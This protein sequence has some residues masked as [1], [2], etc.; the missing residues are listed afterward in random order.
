MRNYLILSDWRCFSKNGRT[1]LNFFRGAVAPLKAEL[2]VTTLI[3]SCIRLPRELAESLMV[4]DRSG[5]VK[6]IYT[7]FMPKIYHPRNSNH[8]ITHLL[9]FAID[10]R[11]T[12]HTVSSISGEI[13]RK[14]NSPLIAHDEKRRKNDAIWKSLK[15]TLIHLVAELNFFLTH[16]C[17][18]T[19]DYRKNYRGK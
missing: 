5:G 7:Q 13:G 11:Y 8:T 2:R 16:L 3:Y 6:T 9:R 19:F 17:T 10:C 1:S 14:R 18:R 4:C 15:L 12:H